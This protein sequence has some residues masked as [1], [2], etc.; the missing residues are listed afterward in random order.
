MSNYNKVILLGRLTR[1]PSL[2]HLPSQM[3]VVNFGMAV[4]KRYTKKDGTE[5]DDTCFIDVKAF[6]KQAE[7]IDKYVGKGD[8]LLIEGELR[9]EKWEDKE[10]RERNKHTIRIN[11]FQLMPKKQEQDSGASSSDDGPPRDEIPF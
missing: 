6:G 5:V 8:L 4:N 7:T 10:G 3:P 1:T 11:G 9:L 2:K